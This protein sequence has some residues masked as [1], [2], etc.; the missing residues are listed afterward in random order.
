MGMSTVNKVS[1][2]VFMLVNSKY[3][4]CSLWCLSGVSRERAA[5]RFRTC[6]AFTGCSVYMLAAQTTLCGHTS[7]QNCK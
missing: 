3:I 7:V 1:F 4:H 6:N 5:L 2:Q